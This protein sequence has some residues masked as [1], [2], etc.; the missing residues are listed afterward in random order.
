MV[1]WGEKFFG[2]RKSQ[3]VFHNTQP[4]S[5]RIYRISFGMM[6]DAELMK[7]QR[8]CAAEE[9]RRGE[10]DYDVLLGQYDY[11]HPGD[12]APATMGDSMAKMAKKGGRDDCKRSRDSLMSTPSIYPQMTGV[13][14]KGPN[15]R[16][17]VKH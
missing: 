10:E 12:G 2:H 9:A 11:P 13:P 5:Q 15:P 14:R 4:Q 3:H 7:L 1:R 16:I 6:H 8:L 17:P